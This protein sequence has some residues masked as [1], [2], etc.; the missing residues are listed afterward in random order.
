MSKRCLRSLAWLHVI[1]ITEEQSYLF[2]FAEAI[3]R[4]K[5]NVW[6]STVWV[7]FNEIDNLLL[8]I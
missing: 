6:E 8:R 7:L 3:E 4:L 2:P 5:P 1:C